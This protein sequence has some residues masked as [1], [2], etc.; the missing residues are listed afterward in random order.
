MFSERSLLERL[1][2]PRTL[3]VR[4]LSENTAELVRSI[5]RHLQRMLNSRQGHAPAQMDYGITEPS[6]VVHNFPEAVGRMQ[7]AI[8]ACIE[9]YE[10]RLNSVTVTHVED[11]DDLFTL[12]FQITAQLATSKEK[13]QVSFDTLMDSGGR[14]Q[15]K[16]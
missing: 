12:R 13:A 2:R 3:G 5:L 6:E 11:E 8:R 9:K 1:A 16:E 15:I 10:P 14:I 4:T 7:R